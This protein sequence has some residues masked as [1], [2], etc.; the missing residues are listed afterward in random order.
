MLLLPLHSHIPGMIKASPQMEKE[1]T[2]Q[3]A[4]A[5]LWSW[6]TGPAGLLL[7]ELVNLSSWDHGSGFV[8]CLVYISISPSL[9]AP[10][11][12]EV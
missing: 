3:L 8:G 1:V 10:T 11:E 7:V 5:G 12:V 6:F 2:L 4:L 9:L